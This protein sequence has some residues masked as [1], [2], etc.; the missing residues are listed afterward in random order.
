MRIRQLRL[1]ERLGFTRAFCPASSGPMAV[2]GRVSALEA[3]VMEPT[4]DVDSPRKESEM[5]KIL[6]A[7]DGTEPSKRA[8]AAAASLG[9][10]FGAQLGVV[11]VVPRRPGRFPT[12]PW[13]NRKVHAAEL[14]EARDLLRA[15]GLEAE[16]IEPVGDPAVMIEHVA[17][18]GGYDTVVVGAR[19]L[20]AI[21]RMLQGSVSA[22]VATHA[23]TTVVVAR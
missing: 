20:G 13:D 4:T 23:S 19:G 18:N 2:A 9:K 3:C 21:D 10:A 1:A 22:H 11:S 17:E 12:D 6:V 15:E 14:V 8:L 5:E 7:Y 16:L